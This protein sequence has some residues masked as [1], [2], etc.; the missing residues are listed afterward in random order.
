MIRLLFAL[1]FLLGLAVLAG[2]STPL[3]MAPA[4]TIPEGEPGG[5]EGPAQ[6]IPNQAWLVAGALVLLGV[7]VFA[8]TPVRFAVFGVLAAGVVVF[9][10]RAGGWLA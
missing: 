9:A 1:G 3:S 8:P 10:A 5:Q 4:N 2:S 7:A 6:A